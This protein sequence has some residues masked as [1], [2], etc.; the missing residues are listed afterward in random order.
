MFTGGFADLELN[1]AQ[2]RYYWQTLWIQ[3]PLV[4]LPEC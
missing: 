1:Y 4:S 2:N 3:V